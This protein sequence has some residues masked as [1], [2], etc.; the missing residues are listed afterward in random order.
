VTVE[1]APGLAVPDSELTFETSTSSGPGGQNVNKVETRVTLLWD[2]TAS[3]SLSDE[4]RGRLTDRLASRLTKDGV[5]RVTSQRHRSQSANREDT[6]ER[7]RELVAEALK[8]RR[9]RRKTKVSRS[10]K[11]RRLEA[12]KRR[13][14]VKKGRG[15]VRRPVD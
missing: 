2:L 15:R 13:S 6:V 5:L 14:E 12:K 3:P 1:L 7:L 4:Q 10:A 8:P 9:K 11:R